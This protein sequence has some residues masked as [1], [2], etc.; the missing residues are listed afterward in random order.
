MFDV[1]WINLALAADSGRKNVDNQEIFHD[2]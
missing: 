1:R 2:Y